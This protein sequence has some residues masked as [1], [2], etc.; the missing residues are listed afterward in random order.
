MPET[1]REV[2]RSAREVNGKWQLQL[3]R[4]QADEIRDHCSNSLIEIGSD[5]RYQP[6]KAGDLLEGL[7]GRF[8]TG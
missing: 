8:F 6:N 1:L 3:S 4:D 7:I 5:E 2:V